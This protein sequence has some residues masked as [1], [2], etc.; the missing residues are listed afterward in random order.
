VLRAGCRFEVL[1][2][3][4]EFAGTAAGTAGVGVEFECVLP[5]AGGCDELDLLPADFV[6]LDFVVLVLAVV[7]RVLALV[8]AGCALEF[9]EGTAGF[10][11][12]TGAGFGETAGGASA[13]VVKTISTG[14]VSATGV[15]AGTEAA[16][17]A[18][19]GAREEA[20]VAIVLAGAAL[21]ETAGAEFVL[22]CTL[23]TATMLTGAGTGAADFATGAGATTLGTG[24]EARAG[25][26]GLF[27]GINDAAAGRAAALAAC[28]RVAALAA[29]LLFSSSS[30]GKPGNVLSGT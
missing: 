3:A 14:A 11:T 21:V 18:G 10:F 30:G 25:V 4:R 29:G 1:S 8:V 23:L 13:D 26:A 24:A 19:T 16:E 2:T 20:D 17:W 9:P 5:A 7:E 6:E 15:F 22:V 27:T 28:A 12:M